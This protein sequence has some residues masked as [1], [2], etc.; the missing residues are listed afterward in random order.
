MSAEPPFARIVAATLVALAVSSL[1]VPAS[2]WLVADAIVAQRPERALRLVPD[3][4]QA[5]E[6]AAVRAFTAGDR[7]SAEA[8]AKAAIAHRPLEGR[9]FRILAA[10]YEESGRVPEARAAHLAA[11][12][13]SPSDAI[14]RLW[15]ASRLLSDG[16][17]DDA[18]G[19][20]DRALRARPDL[21]G[22][23][24]P[25]L[26]GGLG[27]PAFVEALVDALRA[28]PPWREAFLAE[29]M[30]R[31]PTLE[32]L[33]PLVE[34]LAGPG[35][36]PVRE[37]RLL[38]ARLEQDRRWADLRSAWVRFVDPE[39]DPPDRVVDG[40]FERDPHGFGLGWRIARVPGAIVGYAPAQGSTDGGRA[41]SVRFLD[42]RVPFE[43]VQQR[44]L[45]SEGRYRLSGQAR[46]D[47]L[48]ARRGL[49]WAVRC[50]DRQ[51]PLAVGPLVSGTRPWHDWAVEF[52]VPTGCTSQW[53]TLR[54][55]A[56]GPSEQ[57]VGGAAAFDGIEITPA[58]SPAPSV[59]VE[60]VASAAAPRE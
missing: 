3:H 44:L 19:H 30:Q 28:S 58:G 17:Y 43:H 51:E 9:P 32:T 46:A 41:L 38:L 31:G 53:L 23:V 18:L 6:L 7:A 36:L 25:V 10:L 12:A 57:L 60:P 22:S 24:F 20:V 21:S 47:G 33:S 13:V 50:D 49:A 52:A 48:R 39:A 35:A 55:V 45:L 26:T 27:D 56:V 42:Q 2:R 37:A 59:D 54:L 15:I 16:R 4:P 34:G 40:G 5:L 8:L 1:I 29:V 11:I 14:A